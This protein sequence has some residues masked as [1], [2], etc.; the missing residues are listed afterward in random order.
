MKTAAFV[1]LLG[2]LLPAAAQQGDPL[3]SPACGAAL[4][5]L[6]A[7]R[8]A[9]AAPAAVEQLRDAAAGAC[10]GSTTVPTRPA[11]IAQP[12]VVVPPPQVEV[13]LRAAPLPAPVLPPPPVA[14]E[15]PPVPAV[16]DAGGCWS[17]GDTHL[18]HVPPSLAGPRGLCVQQ[19]GLV[20][21]P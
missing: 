9:G 4:S 10:L 2:A 17:G 6:Q 7:A 5:S 13:P 1:L 21:C 11:R 8:A 16:C 15:R 14:V 20:Y 12:P 19:G 3:K 18:R